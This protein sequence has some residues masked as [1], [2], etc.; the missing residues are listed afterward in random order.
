MSNEQYKRASANRV[1][2]SREQIAKKEDKRRE[3]YD[4]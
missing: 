1:G 3:S 4:Y 2:D